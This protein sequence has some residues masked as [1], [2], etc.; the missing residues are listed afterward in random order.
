[1][2]SPYLYLALVSLVIPESGFYVVNVK[3]KVAHYQIKMDFLLS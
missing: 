2:V 1:M 3:V